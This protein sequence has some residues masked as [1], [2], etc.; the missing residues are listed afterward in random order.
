MLCTI[1]G[2]CDGY[3]VGYIVRHALGPYDGSFVGY[4]LG[5]LVG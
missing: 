4:T 2:Y 5:L 1:V 3:D